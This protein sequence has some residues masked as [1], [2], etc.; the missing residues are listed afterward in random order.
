MRDMVISKLLFCLSILSF[1]ARVYALVLY[2]NF[3]LIVLYNSVYCIALNVHT[4]SIGLTFSFA[5]GIYYL[6]NS[7]ICIYSVNDVC[8]KINFKV[9]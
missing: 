7:D 3:K 8:V 6:N 1:E 5:S 2:G 9:M 4:V